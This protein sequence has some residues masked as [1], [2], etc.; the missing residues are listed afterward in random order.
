MG[1]PGRELMN[2]FW[3][4][5]HSWI[6]RTDIKSARQR[7]A[8]SMSQKKQPMRNLKTLIVCGLLEAKEDFSFSSGWDEWVGVRSTGSDGWGQSWLWTVLFARLWSMELLLTTVGNQGLYRI[9]NCLT[10]KQ[11][12][13]NWGQ[14][15]PGFTLLRIDFFFNLVLKRSL[16]IQAKSVLMNISQNVLIIA[17]EAF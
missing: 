8:E 5:V 10:L 6:W 11:M 9:S 1:N 2:P 14:P 13:L 4:G 12:L 15:K 3:E 16:H 7:G 17:A